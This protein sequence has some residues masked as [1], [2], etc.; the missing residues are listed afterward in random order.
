MTNPH[1]LG[2]VQ[3]LLFQLKLSSEDS[4]KEGE[5][6]Y[7]FWEQLSREIVVQVKSYTFRDQF[8]KLTQ[9]ADIHLALLSAHY[10]LV[11]EQLRK[12]K[13]NKG[14]LSYIDSY[15]EHKRLRKAQFLFSTWRFP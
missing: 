8:F 6:T 11:A 2:M 3:N 1:D 4:I 12:V 15:R 13:V 7:D 10:Y 9:N 14:D 5:G